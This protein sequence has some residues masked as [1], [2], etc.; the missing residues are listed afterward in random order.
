VVSYADHAGVLYRDHLGAKYMAEPLPQLVADSK[1]LEEVDVN[2]DGWMDV[3]S[4]NGTLMNM[5]GGFRAAP[6]PVSDGSVEPDKPA[7]KSHWIRI[8]LTG[9]KNLKLGYGSEVEVKSGTF[10][11]KKA[12]DGAPLLFDLGTRVTV[13]AVR[14]TWPNGLIQN[15]ANQ[16]VD[17]SYN[18]KEAQRLSGSCPMIWTWNGKH[19]GFI[20]DV[21]GVAPLGASS[22]DGQYFPVDHDEYIQIPGRELAS[23]NG[24][25]DVRI[26]EEL[27]EVSYLDQAQLLAIDHPADSDVFTSE[28]WKGPPFPEFRIYTVNRVDGR[29]RPKAARDGQGRD[30]LE[31]LLSRD[32]KYVDTF[33]HDHAGVADSHTLDLDFGP[34][35]ARDNKAVLVLNGWVDWADGS[36]FLS[37]SQEGKGGLVPP[38]LQVRDRNGNWKTVIDDMGMPD[39]KPKT[40]AVDL[41]G[42]F[43][44]SSRELRIVTNLCVF[45]DEIFLGEDAGAPRV[46]VSAA[47]LESAELQF[48]G[49]SKPVI[50]ADRLRPETFLYDVVSPATSWNPTPGLYTR[51]GA[52]KELMQNV[53]DLLVIMGSGDQMSLRYRADK[54]PPIPAG[55]T[56]DYLL[57]VD[58]WAKDRDANTAFSQSV[59]PLPFHAMSRYPYSSNEHFPSDSAHQAYRREYNTRPAATLILPLYASGPASK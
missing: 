37:A 13:D 41:T 12:Y 58:G 7:A 5:Q 56:R 42:K 26:T 57:K 9:V 31:R 59:E 18:Y 24:R 49:F 20:S 36:T 29:V 53:D 43:L 16:A 30:V 33:G 14:I 45:W 1:W 51:Y 40:I 2:H 21:L 28:R 17:R 50:D 8:Q 23:V 11:R 22:G 46:R 19:F 55:W 6:Q 32:G 47:P 27:S 25:L 48:R 54:L 35:A 4:S 39:G 34:G 15:E 10:Y 3:A 38:Y 44:S 52:V